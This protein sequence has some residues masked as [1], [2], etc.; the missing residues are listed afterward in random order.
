VSVRQP[1]QSA[2]LHV[3]AVRLFL[4]DRSGLPVAVA[5]DS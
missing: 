2:V 5:P 3:D 4:F 1:D